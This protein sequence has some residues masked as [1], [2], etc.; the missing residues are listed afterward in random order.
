MRHIAFLLVLG[1]I[2]CDRRAIPG[3]DLGAASFG[4][5]PIVLPDRGASARLDGVTPEVCLRETS[6]RLVSD[7]SGVM[8]LAL[9]SPEASAT[10]VT[11]SGAASGEAALAVN[12]PPLAGLAAV[13]PT[14]QAPTA[15][16]AAIQKRF[17]LLLAAAKLGGLSVR[18][19]GTAG[20]NH[21]GQ[22]DVKEAI[23]DLEAAGAVE[24]SAIRAQLLA[25]VLDR[26]L[27]ALALPMGPVSAPAPQLTVKLSV[28]REGGGVA[29]SAAVVSRAELDGSDEVAFAVDDLANGTALAGPKR[30]VLPECDV[31][32]ADGSAL[33]DILWVIDESGSM[34]DNRKDIVAHAN[35]FFARAQAAGLDLRMGVTGVKK[36]T[37]EA[38]PGKLCSRAPP[39]EPADDGGED[40]FLSPGEHALFSACVENPPYYEGSEE[41]GLTAIYWAIKRHLPRAKSS[42]GKIRDGAKLAIV[43]ATDEAPEEIKQGGSFEGRAG[44]FKPAELS[45]TSCPLPAARQ[46]ALDELLRPLRELFTQPAAQATLHVIGGTCNNACKA[47]LAVGYR[48]LAEELGGQVG[49]VCQHDLNATIDVVIDSIA[50]SASPRIL[51]HVPVSSTLAVEGNGLRLP[52]SRSKGFLYNAATNSLTFVNVKLVKGDQVVAAYRRFT[53]SL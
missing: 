38:V 31:G 15:E 41:Y 5:G 20:K 47:E 46:A 23:W 2:A 4:D 19:S 32:T 33:A 9:A 48:E 40:R 36:P 42:P 35:A 22:P 53:G 28:A 24:P 13:R 30:G 16:L 49:D 26:P 14:A 39:S 8:T 3:M 43:V 27:A 12:Q 17:T 21:S 34:S 37:S 44:F 1:L 11:V 45:S 6:L 52:R 18:A 7:P 51:A 50:A 10:P 29:V 25:A